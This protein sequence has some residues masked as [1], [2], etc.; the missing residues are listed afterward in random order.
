MTAIWDKFCGTLGHVHDTR[1]ETKNLFNP[2]M[3]FF[4]FSEK[5]QF[6]APGKN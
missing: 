1:I 2:T 3:R 6:C 5:L 4:L